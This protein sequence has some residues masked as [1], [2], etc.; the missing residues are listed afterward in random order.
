MVALLRQGSV[1]SCKHVPHVVDHDS[2]D[3]GKRL[4]CT[5]EGGGSNT[6]LVNFSAVLVG[7]ALQSQSCSFALFA[8]SSADRSTDLSV[9]RTDSR[10]GESELIYGLSINSVYGFSGDKAYLAG[11]HQPRPAHHH[12]QSGQRHCRKVRWAARHAA[13]IHLPHPAHRLRL[14]GHEDRRYDVRWALW[15][16]FQSR[17]KCFHA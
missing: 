3:H 17:W 7:A 16:R 8:A 12:R 1:S 15:K 14:T 10:A 9:C 13:R 11:C 2:T 5:D 6:S 4:G